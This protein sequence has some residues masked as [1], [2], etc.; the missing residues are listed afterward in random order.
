VASVLSSTTVAKSKTDAVV[1]VEAI[2][3]G[4]FDGYTDDVV[5][6][7]HSVEDPP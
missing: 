2:R 7:L 5:P 3:I 4:C 6:V 1:G